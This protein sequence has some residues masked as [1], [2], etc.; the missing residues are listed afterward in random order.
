MTTNFNKYVIYIILLLACISCEKAKSIKAFPEEYAGVGMELE[1]IGGFPRIVR[2]IPGSS[3]EDTSLRTGDKILKI[4]DTN[5]KGYTLAKI[6]GLLRGK[7][8]SKVTILIQHN[9]EKDK[10]NITLI[11]KKISLTNKRNVNRF[12]GD[13]YKAN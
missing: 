3:A 8:N 1:V 9:E 11:R 6:V 13:D 12:T 4:N 2:I 5:V 10:H 7:I